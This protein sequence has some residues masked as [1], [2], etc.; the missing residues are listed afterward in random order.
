MHV[1]IVALLAFGAVA[2]YGLLGS[3]VLTLVDDEHGSL[4]RWC[5]S[6]DDD[7]VAGVLGLAWPWL[8]WRWWR[9]C[10]QQRQQ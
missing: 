8:A 6:I 7:M 9:H 5:E 1:L 3:I 2:A 4:L 10:R